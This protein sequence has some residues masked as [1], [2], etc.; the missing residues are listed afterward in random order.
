MVVSVLVKND[1]GLGTCDLCFVPVVPSVR[2]HNVDALIRSN[3]ILCAACSLWATV[4][5]GY[6]HI[7]RVL[8]RA[9]F[10]RS[11]PAPSLCLC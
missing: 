5:K 2:A 1:L 6:L 10:K 3:F 9:K 4:K 7:L 8:N 11:S